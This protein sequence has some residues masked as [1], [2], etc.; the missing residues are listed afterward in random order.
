MTE[1][2]RASRTSAFLR[3]LLLLQR[4][5]RRPAVTPLRSF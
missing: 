4:S 5:D 2:Q 1:Q 3:L